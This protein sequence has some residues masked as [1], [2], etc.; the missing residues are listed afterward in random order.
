MQTGG[1]LLEAV[2]EELL[3]QRFGVREGGDAVAEVSRREDA[4][5]LAEAPGAATIVRHGD[6]CHQVPGA[7]LEA[8]QQGWQPRA[9]TNG[10]DLRANFALAEPV[11]VEDIADPLRPPGE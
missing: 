11:I 8:T 7:F 4:E 6:N 3:H 9:A 10:D 1:F 5:L 2:L